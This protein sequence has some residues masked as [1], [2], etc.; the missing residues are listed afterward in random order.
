MNFNFPE[1]SFP[2]CKFMYA[3]AD[4]PVRALGTEP[5]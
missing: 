1:S 2:D 5:A 4:I 3:G